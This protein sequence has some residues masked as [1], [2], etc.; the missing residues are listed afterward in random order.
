M[1]EPAIIDEGVHGNGAGINPGFL[2]RRTLLRDAIVA[3]PTSTSSMHISW[4][5]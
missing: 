2:Y 3:K 5:Q 4:M 1:Q